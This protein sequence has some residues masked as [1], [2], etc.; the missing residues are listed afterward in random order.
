MIVALWHR[1]THDHRLRW[2]TLCLAILALDVAIGSW[3]I[4]WE[5]RMLREVWKP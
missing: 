5:L 2:L 1:W 3:L 4:A